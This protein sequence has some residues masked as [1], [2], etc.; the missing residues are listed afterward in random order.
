MA[1]FPVFGGRWNL[2]HQAVK[3]SA[4]GDHSFSGPAPCLVFVSVEEEIHCESKPPE[5]HVGVAE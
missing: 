4:L 5:V 1:G 3:P 2:V